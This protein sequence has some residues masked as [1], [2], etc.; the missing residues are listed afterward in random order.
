VL[1]FEVTGQG[2]T[3]LVEADIQDVFDPHPVDL[4]EENHEL[5]CI[6]R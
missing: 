1:A 5:Q 3:D 2:F 4:T 6:R